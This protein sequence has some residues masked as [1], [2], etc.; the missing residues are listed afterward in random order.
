MSHISEYM[1]KQMRYAQIDNIPLLQAYG[2]ESEAKGKTR[3]TIATVNNGDMA[4][5]PRNNLF[6]FLVSAFHKIA[7]LPSWFWSCFT[8]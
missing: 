2:S 4:I 3:L 5:A 8:D 1:L 7:L 6:S